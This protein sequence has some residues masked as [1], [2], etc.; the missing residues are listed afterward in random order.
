MCNTEYLAEHGSHTS[1]KMHDV[2]EKL[3]FKKGIN[4]NKRVHWKDFNM[5][6][7]WLLTN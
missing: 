5:N 2:I 1:G 7:R 3:R 6:K 4:R